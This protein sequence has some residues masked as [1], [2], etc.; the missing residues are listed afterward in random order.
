MKGNNVTHSSTRVWLALAI[1]ATGGLRAVAADASVS[2]AGV[3]VLNKYCVS[4][5]GPEKQKG[6]LRLDSHTWLL[7]SGDSG[8]PL[9]NADNAERSR[10][11]QRVAVDKDMPPEGHPAPESREQEALL[12]WLKVGAI[13]PEQHAELA[14][15]A[16]EVLN[17]HC[18]RCHGQQ[19]K[20]PGLDV[21]HVATLTQKLPGKTRPYVIA[22]NPSESG[23]WLKVQDGSMPPKTQPRLSTDEK[24]VLRRWIE[25][26]APAFS[27]RTAEARS[28]VSAEDVRTAILNHLRKS[29]SSTRRHLR[30]FT[31]DHLNNCAEVTD[32][33]LRTFR[34]ALSKLVNSLTWESEIVVPRAIDAQQT[35]FVVDLRELGWTEVD[36]WNKVLA[37]YPYGLE[38]DDPDNLADE[39]RRLSG[40]SLVRLAI[41][42]DWFVTRASRPPLYNKLLE[43]PETVAE[44]E[45]RLEVKPEDDFVNGSL[46][47][48]VLFQS[49]VS[50]QNRL[51]DRHRSIHGAYWKSYDFGPS[52]AT[53]DLLQRPLGPK[54]DKNTFGELAF[55]H[56]GGEMIFSLPN[57]LHGYYLA[58]KDGKQINKGPV[59][60]VRDS[61]ETS[62]T[63]EIVT[64]LSC[65]ACHKNGVVWFRDELRQALTLTGN[66][67]RKLE[68]L[69]ATHAE[70]DDRL[71][72]DEER[73][74]SALLEAISPFLPVTSIDE[75]RALSDEPVAVFARFYQ[76][77]MS[78][79]MVAAELGMRNPDELKPLLGRG[80]VPTVLGPLRNGNLIKRNTWDDIQGKSNSNFQKMADELDVGTPVKIN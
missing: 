25:I 59:E 55:V 47:R 62:G 2:A 1:L 64:G 34:A 33:Q 8:E 52:S 63:P 43:L 48:G 32:G 26:G 5:H 14:G 23:L 69:F 77:D 46:Q 74:L 17:R 42:A 57:R 60:I 49:K 66:T 39:I 53:G 75:V 21:R 30:F 70:M 18:F 65:I 72:R 6:G 38:I 29:R 73:Y 19:Q 28:F 11:W 61:N 22:G 51:L 44:L 68:D 40:N 76:A 78:L 15:R 80:N 12:Q 45:K 41:R 37:E 3:A 71:R 36:H 50:T 4:C 13:Y 79:Q 20:T 10:L 35:V 27:V 9:L 67:R 58:D 24:D 7:K 54:F 56:D 16:F 31:M